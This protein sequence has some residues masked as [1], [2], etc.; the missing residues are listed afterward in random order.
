MTGIFTLDAVVG[1]SISMMVLSASILMLSEP[2][3]SNRENVYQISTDVLTILDENGGL[4]R[5]ANHDGSMLGEIKSALPQKYCIELRIRD[6]NDNI[7]F[8]EDEDCIGSEYVI[9]RRNFMM[10]REPY[11]AEI[12]MWYK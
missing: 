4:Q 2:K 12:R 6:T 7:V 5:L 9:S 1:L 3:S 11:T 10:E 8:Q